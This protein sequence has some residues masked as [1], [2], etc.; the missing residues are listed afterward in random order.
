MDK[1]I[2]QIPGEI[3]KITTMS[4]KAL[5][6]QID[7]Q[8]EVK[9]EQIEKL[10]AVYETYGWFTFLVRDDKGKIKPEEVVDLP[11][12]DNELF[13]GKKSLKER[14]RNVQFVYYKQRKIGAV[15][16]FELWRARETERMITKYKEKLEPNETP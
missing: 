14:L 15:E 1:H 8:E 2:F 12:I 3:T 11:P 13:K 4:R 5:R 16:D 9:G 7:T 10:M 6:L